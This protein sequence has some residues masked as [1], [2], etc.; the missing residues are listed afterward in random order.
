MPRRCSGPSGPPVC[1]PSG[2]EL[3]R[4]SAGTA[5]RPRPPPSWRLPLS[6]S[7]CSRAVPA[8]AP[9][10][11]LAWRHSGHSPP[12]LPRRLQRRAQL[13][14]VSAVCF[15]LGVLPPAAAVPAARARGLRC[16]EP[17]TRLQGAEAAD[18]MSL[19]PM[20]G[21]QRPRAAAAAAGH[22]LLWLPKSAAM[23]GPASCGLRASND[24][25]IQVVV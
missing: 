8:A 5:R 9:G 10:C 14:L 13:L 6:P 22:Q 19:G 18:R 11:R 24:I 12:W 2:P 15:A 20:Q 7:R 17:G 4:R 21:P 3:R 23:P 25:I 16:A 1:G